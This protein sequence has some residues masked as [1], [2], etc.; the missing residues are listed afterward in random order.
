VK[1]AEQAAIHG[2]TAGH[3]MIRVITWPAT[4]SRITITQPS[5]TCLTPSPIPYCAFKAQLRQGTAGRPG[6]GCRSYQQQ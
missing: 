2:G 3:S 6:A 1:T 5:M 4:L